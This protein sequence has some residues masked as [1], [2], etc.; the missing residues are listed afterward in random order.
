MSKKNGPWTINSS[1]IKYK[2]PWIEVVE[3]Q[4]IRP[5]GKPGI[6]GVVNMQ[7]GVSV[8]AMDGEGNVYLTKEFRYG[9]QQ[10]SVEVVSGGI[11]EGETPRKAA[12]RELKEEI[13]A[14]SSDWTD[15]GLLNPFTSVVKSPAHLFLA[16]NLVFGE[17][18]REGTEQITLFKVPFTEA[19]RM[20]M[21]SE[22]TH[23]Q[24]CVLILK[25]ARYLEL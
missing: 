22:I 16:R 14:V 24:S 11:D 7:A 23:G 20:V 2:N 18:E 12:E 21:E 8:L 1:E 13:G 6:F 25:A 5:D 4:V 17:N 10:D 9:L 19:V 3:D 15:L